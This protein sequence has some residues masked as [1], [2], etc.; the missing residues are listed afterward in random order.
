MKLKKKGIDIGL[1]LLLKVLP[2]IGFKYKS[3]GENCKV[4]IERF[5]IRASRAHYLRTI[6]DFRRRGYRIV[7]LE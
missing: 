3:V 6:K 2:E 1:N 5:E 4:L 7:H